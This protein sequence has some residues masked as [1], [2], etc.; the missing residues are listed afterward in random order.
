MSR[1]TKAVVLAA[2]LGTRMRAADDGTLDPAQARAADAGMK[3]MMPFGRPFLD[4]ALHTLADAGIT[5]VCLV[6]G[7]AH[8][9]VRTYYGGLETDRLTIAFAVQHE[10]KGTADAVAA[11]RPFTA[12]DHFLVVNAD[13][14]Y[15]VDA[16]RTLADHGIAAAAA[17]SRAGLLRDGQIASE[18][19]AR[20]ALIE[21]RD[22]WL[23]RVRE[24]PG[25]AAV[26]AAGDTAYVSMNCWVL[27]PAV[28]DVIGTMPL[29]PRGE[30]ELPLAVQS[31]V[32]R[33]VPFRVFYFNEPVLDLSHRSDVA[34]VAGRL[35]GRPVSL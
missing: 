26:A 8:D 30:L 25:T 7:P 11:A 23:T 14:L 9:A 17:F 27:P 22:G 33:G 32:D 2:G 35:R 10:P 13:N 28:F 15:P 12:A 20:F 4:Y 31:L 34:F 29:S 19:L 6:I 21:S 16:C 18:R 24:K 5:D 1:V 3:A